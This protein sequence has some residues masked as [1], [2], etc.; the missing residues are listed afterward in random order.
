VPF[1]TH[2]HTHTQYTHVIDAAPE[3]TAFFIEDW[4]QWENIE[5]A[6]TNDD[7]TTEPGLYYGAQTEELETEDTHLSSV[8]FG[9]TDGNTPA[10]GSLLGAWSGMNVS[11]STLSSDG[12]FTVNI[13]NHAPRGEFSGDGVDALGKFTVKGTIKEREVTI[14]KEYSASQGGFKSACTYSGTLN[15]DG[16]EINGVITQGSGDG[17]QEN[18]VEENGEDGDGGEDKDGDEDEDE[19]EDEE[20]SASIAD[21]APS[22]VLTDATE[23]KIGGSFTLSRKPVEYFI[24]RPRA[25]EY[26]ENQA[27]A[28]WKLVRNVSRYWAQR[29]HLR[30]DVLKER[31]E[32]RN[33]YV[34]LLWKIRD[35]GRLRNS[36]QAAKWSELVRSTHPDDLNLWRSI[37]LFKRLRQPVTE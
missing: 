30:W 36:E 27:Q 11:R 24:C 34:D 4:S 23:P 31:R 15:E 1:H 21:T 35:Y 14:F 29:R 25:E 32:K 28:L 7:G 8:P 26:Q 13:T 17:S 5:Y 22:S 37:T 19:D 9:N 6:E 16:D 2:T 20:D 33:L 18:Q 10:L 12:L 3:G